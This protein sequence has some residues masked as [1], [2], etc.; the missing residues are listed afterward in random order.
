MI[1]IAYIYIKK[2]MYILSKIVF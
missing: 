1:F 2:Y